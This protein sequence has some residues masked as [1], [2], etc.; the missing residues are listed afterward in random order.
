MLRPL[1]VLALALACALPAA[2]QVDASQ[3]PDD[4][5]DWLPMADAVAQARAT[6]KTL[7]V[8]TYAVWCGWCARLDTDVYTDD[9]VQAYLAEHFVATRVNTES[10]DVVPFFDFSVS[11]AGLAQAFRVTGTP[12]TVFVSPEGELI[13]R[14]PGF[15][16]AE[17]FRLTLRYVHEKAYESE[18][19]GEF[20]NRVNNTGIP[21][22]RP[23]APDVD[24]RG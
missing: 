2:A 17:T 16:P 22:L 24:T 4:A 13:T 14:L 11:M 9:D 10:Q 12:T 21:T 19:F 20:Q 8:H 18:S 3:I 5:P 1:L 6:G 23:A 15:A 7:V